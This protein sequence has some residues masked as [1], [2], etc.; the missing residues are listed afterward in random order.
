MAILDYR[1]PETLSEREPPIITLPEI[2]FHGAAGILIPIGCFVGS[3]F[4]LSGP[5]RL[6]QSEPLASTRAVLML[7]CDCSWPFWPL[8]AFSM[9]C[10][11][12]MIV[13][14]RSAIADPLVRLGLYTGVLLALQ[15]SLIVTVILLG[16]TGVYAL[17]AIAVPSIAVALVHPVRLLWI[18]YRWKSFGPILPLC[19]VAMFT[20]P[21]VGIFL[22]VGAP[23]LTLGSYFKL[24]R[25]VWRLCPPSGEFSW[26]RWFPVLAWLAALGVAWRMSVLRVLYEYTQLPAHPSGCYIATAAACGHRRLVRSA[27]CQAADGTGFCVTR[28]LRVLK[29]AE[30]ILMHT[31]PSLHRS[32]RN[33]YDRLGPPLARRM[34][35]PL[36]AD[37]AYLSIKPFEWA[38]IVLMRLLI[39]DALHLLPRIY[40][41]PIAAKRGLHST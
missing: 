35:H 14:P 9:Y 17:P 5:L 38:A 32:C 23:F 3:N 19:I 36:L 21:P 4:L 27:Q 24:S 40:D 12:K 2:L 39:P 34:S 37:I 1:T 15:C 25:T 18:R 41:H 22:L 30:L 11:G 6:N 20:P 7:R 26:R 10:L 29:C 16:T 31:C 8:L 13:V 28:Q 33:A